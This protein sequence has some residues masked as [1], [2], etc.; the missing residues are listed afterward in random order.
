MPMASP[1]WNSVELLAGQA[2]PPNPLSSWLFIGG[3]ILIFYLLMIR[4]QM[5]EQKKRREMLSQLKKND[6]VVTTSGMYG[7]IVAI[8]DRTVTLKV[9]DNV[10]IRFTRSAVDHIVN[11]EDGGAFKG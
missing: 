11:G 7:Q 9:D 8:D 4:P 10:R 6:K 1:L 2:P 5:K 3:L